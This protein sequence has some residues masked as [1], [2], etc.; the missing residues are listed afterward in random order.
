V[1]AK[2]VVTVTSQNVENNTTEQL[3]QVITDLLRIGEKANRLGNVEVA[4]VLV[5]PFLD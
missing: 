2:V 4:C 5:V 1:I 3:L